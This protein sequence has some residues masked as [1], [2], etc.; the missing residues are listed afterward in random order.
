MGPGD[1]ED[2]DEGE[3]A[4]EEDSSLGELWPECLALMDKG[5]EQREENERGHSSWHCTTNNKSLDTNVRHL[6]VAS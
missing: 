6:R 5:G 2:W 4:E 3:V 1:A